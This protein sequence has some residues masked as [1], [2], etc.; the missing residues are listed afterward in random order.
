MDPF[1]R[2]IT[3]N[4][5]KVFSRVSN[6]LEPKWVPNRTPRLDRKVGVKITPQTV[7]IFTT[8]A[9]A[10]RCNLTYAGLDFHAYMT[11]TGHAFYVFVTNAGHGFTYVLLMCDMICMYLLFLR[12]DFLF[13][14]DQRGA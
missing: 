5:L 12:D 7:H 9:H 1:Q 3:E 8:L 4:T 11:Y 10:L 6:A 13:I 2:L 14:L